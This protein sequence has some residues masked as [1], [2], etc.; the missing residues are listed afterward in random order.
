MQVLLLPGDRPPGHLVAVDPSGVD[1]M[2]RLDDGWCAALDR[3]T[4][5]CTI[6]SVRPRLCRDYAMGGPDCLAER[7]AWF[8]SATRPA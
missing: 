2:A 1:V 8:G 4:M 7:A 5:R 6:Y 3:N